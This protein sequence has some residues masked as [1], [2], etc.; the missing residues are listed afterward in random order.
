MLIFTMNFVFL[1]LLFIQWNLE[2]FDIE[3]YRYISHFFIK[4]DETVDWVV[5]V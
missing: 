5:Q 2:I 4:I 1:S 3:Y